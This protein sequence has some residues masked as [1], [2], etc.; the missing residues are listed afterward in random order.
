MNAFFCI[1]NGQHE[2]A[3]TLLEVMVAL[4]IIAFSFVALLSSQSQSI[5]IAS[6]AR[7]E[8]TASLL[9]RQKLAELE[10]QDFEYL[11]SGTGSFDAHFSGYEWQLEVRP[12]MEDESGIAE[13]HGML[14]Q[15]T[16]TIVHGK[17]RLSVQTLLMAPIAADAGEG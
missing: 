9:A 12:L 8:T 13:S 4:A 14:K 15:I 6:I 5:A 1:H 2:A 10:V 7:F 11:Y 17:D 3:F 16:V